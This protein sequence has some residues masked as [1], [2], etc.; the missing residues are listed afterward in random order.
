MKIWSMKK[1]EKLE[2]SLLNG[3]EALEMDAERA[4][5]YLMVDLY[6]GTPLFQTER[7]SSN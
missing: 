4:E 6:S 1:M 3:A 7:E 5:R 2:E